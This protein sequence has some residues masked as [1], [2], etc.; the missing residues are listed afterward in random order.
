MSKDKNTWIMIL[1]IIGI[2]FVFGM[3]FQK[4]APDDYPRFSILPEGQN[5]HN[6]NCS[7]ITNID[8]GEIW[9]INDYQ[10]NGQWIA[11]D[12]DGTGMKTYSAYSFYQGGPNFCEGY[13]L[14]SINYLNLN[15]LGE[16]KM[17]YNSD[18]IQG[19]L[20]SNGNVVTQHYGPMIFIC[21][22]DV[23][24]SYILNQ[25]ISVNLDCTQQNITNTTC[26]ENWNCGSWSSCSS[27]TQTRVCTDLNSCGTT[28]SKPL[29]SQTCGSCV[30][31]TCESLG[32]ECG[33]VTEGNCGNEL[34]CG[35]CSSG[36]TCDYDGTCVN[37]ESNFDLSWLNKEIYNLFGF[38]ITI[39]MAIA[40]ALILIFSIIN[41]K[42]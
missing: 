5:N 8:P 19:Y 35:T 17:K 34:N 13:F 7:F 2:I 30:P 38:S 36:Q 29:E 15:A 32:H 3:F 27:G 22:N 41:Y 20:D 40:L 14:Q 24:K 33:V 31:D 39:Y 1:V 6:S 25:N 12:A 23:A 10:P 21:H 9:D 26:V 4:N 11:L 18:Y 28:G 42:K 37:E 16:F